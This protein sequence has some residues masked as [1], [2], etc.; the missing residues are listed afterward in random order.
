MA[1]PIG[2]LDNKYGR[3]MS[4]HAHELVDRLPRPECRWRWSDVDLTESEL[5]TLR[6]AGLIEQV[7]EG[8]WRT[9]R[10]CIQAVADYGRFECADVGIHVGQLVLGGES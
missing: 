6:R 9:T 10:R 1:D 2:T 8:H 3:W 5:K 7:E 4:A